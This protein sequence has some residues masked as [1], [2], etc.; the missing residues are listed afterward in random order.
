MKDRAQSE[1]G[2]GVEGAEEIRSIGVVMAEASNEDGVWGAWI[3]DGG[4]R[5]AGEGAGGHDMSK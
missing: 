1:L 5:S 3:G 4:I 2:G